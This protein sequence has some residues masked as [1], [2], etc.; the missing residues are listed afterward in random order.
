[1]AELA[2]LRDANSHEE[3]HRVSRSRTI[4]AGARRL[5]LFEKHRDEKTFRFR[6]S[7]GF[8]RA[9]RQTPS[10]QQA[11]VHWGRHERGNDDVPNRGDL[12][13]TMRDPHRSARCPQRARPSSRS[14]PPVPLQHGYERLLLTLVGPN[15]SPQLARLPRQES[16]SLAAP[17][18]AALASPRL[19]NGPVRQAR[20][21]AVG[22]CTISLAV[23]EVRPLAS[24]SCRRIPQYP[25]N[26]VLWGW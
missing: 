15:V 6:R 13:R 1:M 5:G 10:W 22:A 12:R 9:M 17:C 11:C 16:A 19:A 23:H 8:Y 7:R 20:A 21:I 24:S 2:E 3:A 25:W 14:H 4:E 18:L 26:L